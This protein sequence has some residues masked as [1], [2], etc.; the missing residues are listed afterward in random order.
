VVAIA[1]QPDTL[2]V[3]HVGYKG[4]VRG[5]ALFELQGCENSVIDL[6]AQGLLGLSHFGGEQ[7]LIRL[8]DDEYVD[9]A[10]RIGFIFG[11]GPI[12]PGRLDTGDASQCL[13]QSRL[14]AH[15]SPEQRKH[16]AEVWVFAI[17]TVIKLASLDLWTKKALVRQS[18]ELAA[19]V[20]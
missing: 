15:R 16:L 7:C 2:A 20:G 8:A 12:D 19:K 13:A 9:V 10:C 6:A 1:N 4:V 18:L 3:P 11:E 5:K 17:H 14:D